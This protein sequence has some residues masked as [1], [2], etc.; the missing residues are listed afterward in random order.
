VLIGAE[1]MGPEQNRPGTSL[2]VVLNLALAGIALTAVYVPRVPAL[3][4]F[5]LQYVMFVV[6]WAHT[7]T[8]STPFAVATYQIY[9][10]ATIGQGLVLWR[11]FDL[12]Y[13]LVWCVAAPLAAYAVHP[14]YGARVP[15]SIVVT[16]PLAV[17]GAR[18]G[19]ATLLR[20]TKSLDDNRDRS[21]RSQARLDVQAA[22]LRRAAEEQ[23]QVH[24][25]AINTLAAVVRGGSAVADVPAVRARCRADA[26]VLDQ[27]MSATARPVA[28]G[29]APERLSAAR[30]IEVTL[31]GLS[32]PALTAHWQ[33]LPA[34]VQT[35][36]GGAIVELVTNAEKHS[37]V[38]E[39]RV[40][41]RFNGTGVV[42][43]VS[44]RGCGFDQ[45]TTA[46][47]GI[48]TS[49]R[50]RLQEAG[51]DLALHSAQGEGVRAVMQWKAAGSGALE[52]PSDF[53]RDVDRVRM[54]GALLLTAGVGVGGYF[55]GFINHPGVFTPDYVL[56]TFVLAIAGVAWRSWR[57]RGRLTAPVGWA[58]IVASPVAF[59]ISGTSVHF[60][61]GYN[62][63]WQALAPI[64]PLWILV[65]GARRPRIVAVGIA[66]HSAV[67]LIAAVVIP[68][69]RAGTATAV[70]VYLTGV[71]WVLGWAVCNRLLSRLASRAAADLAATMHA[72]ET[73][74]AREE[75]DLIRERWR[76]SGI[77]H[78]ADLL[79]ELGDSMDPDTE[80]ARARCGREETYLR[81]VVLLPPDLVHI[82]TWFCEA[83]ASARDRD[84]R[85]KV[86][87][88]TSDVP[89]DA[90]DR[91]GQYLVEATAAA[92]P[93]T[94]MVASLFDP[95][96]GPQFRLVSQSRGAASMARARDW[97]GGL[98]I[99]LQEVADP[100]LREVAP[101]TPRTQ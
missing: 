30:S 61:H 42:A 82:G 95:G 21:A 58:L 91:L 53:R 1:L 3:L 28:A 36:L 94:E 43:V 26:A 41:I 44:D 63:A 81:E 76:R 93:G 90:A 50:E 97:G 65:A 24:D 39:V 52:L 33:R 59:L 74:A 22:T 80:S 25:T 49:V 98:T 55:I 71:V 32:G 7:A 16:L 73:A 4:V 85:L 87:S 67:S 79:R 20:L 88:G 5:Q 77:E 34:G 12:V 68:E 2:V 84:V 46:E 9:I 57:R 62:L 51:I 40:D 54:I 83:L 23:R 27:L 17:V 38:G 56:C 14:D 89:I 31:P 101:R 47:R 66:V 70:V 60:G 72:E 19:V 29:F 35:A 11:R 8:P 45:A 78:A 92:E 37:G 96:D 18:P 13:S 100:V 48:R 69:S 6:N 86:R 75:A 15:L 10:F 64:A 99:P